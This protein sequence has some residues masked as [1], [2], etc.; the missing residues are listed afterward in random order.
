[1]ATTVY[2]GEIGIDYGDDSG[3]VT[4]KTNS[5]FQTLSRLYFNLLKMS[6]AGK[7]PGVDFLGTALVGSF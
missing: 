2:E 7:F 4:F 1:M 5:L 6:N 3:T